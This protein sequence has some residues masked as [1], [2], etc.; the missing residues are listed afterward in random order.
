[1]G[2]QLP[3]LFLGNKASLLIRKMAVLTNTVSWTLVFGLSIAAFVTLTSGSL[4]FPWLSC[5]QSP[6]CLKK[7]FPASVQDWLP[8]TLARPANSH[9][10]RQDREESSLSAA[11]SSRSSH[12]HA[13]GLKHCE[14]WSG[15]SGQSSWWQYVVFTWPTALSLMC[16]LIIGSPIQAATGSPYILDGCVL[17]FIWISAVRLQ[18]GFKHSRLW[19]SMPRRKSAIA[20]LM[21]PVLATT[22]LMIGYTR[23]KAAAMGVNLK[24]VLG[25]FSSGVPLWVFWTSGVE[26]GG[27]TRGSFFGPGD[28]AMSMLECGLLS[29]G[30][31]LFECRLQVLSLPGLFC[32]VL[33]IAA[34]AGNV[35]LSVLCARTIGLATSGALAFAARSTTLALAGP[36][37]RIVGGDLAAN[38]ALVVT[39]GVLGQLLYPFILDKIG[40]QRHGVPPSQASQQ[41]PARFVRAGG[42]AKQRRQLARREKQTPERREDVNWPEEEEVAD[43]AVT[44]AAGTAIG[45]NGAAMG[46]AY[47]YETRSRAA[48][49][50]ALSMTVFGVMTVVFT[51][52]EPFRGCL[53]EL[54]MSPA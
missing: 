2:P 29:W 48:P 6:R 42:D 21:N 1:M 24:D 9:H 31:K 10:R 38:A 16:I 53:I 15:H 36:A 41:N 12:S 27:L 20:T 14:R 40:V 4:M 35:F 33:S 3:P 25:P 30:F 5:H 22:L 7:L 47:L 39:N 49:Y 18:K 11:Q 28:A 23:I 44:M 17:W 19:A 26:H 43:S 50:A 52:V 51:T 37:M 34:A 8:N 13:E 54:A 32:A 45:I 46:V